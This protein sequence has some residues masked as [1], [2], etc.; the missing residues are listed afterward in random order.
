[1]SKKNIKNKPKISIII[2]TWNTSAITQKC[3]ATIQKHLPENFYEIIIVDNGSQDDTVSKLKKYNIKIIENK[4]NLGFAKANNI[5]VKH[6]EGDYL[7]FLNSDMELIDDSLVQM[8]SFLKDNENIG[9]IGPM[10]LNT[11]LTP[12]ASVFPPQNLVNA[13][14][15]FWLKVPAYSKY[16]P[17][18]E[19]PSKVYSISGG[20]FLITKKLF[21]QINGWN[22][23]YFFYFEDLDLCRQINSHSKDVYFYP[24]CKVIHHHGASGKN[25]SDT[26]N[27]WRR[28][29]PGS[30]KYH[31]LI[32][33][34]LINFVIWSGQ[35]WHQL[36]KTGKK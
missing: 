7:L 9:A 16:I 31:G 20:A 15:E 22:E 12:Q 19:K 13:F 21:K 18:S 17:A 28:L 30:I 32:K 5:G 3:V 33:H 34:Y 11:D 27:Q 2:V 35:K 14:K 25:L 1:M 26:S 6:A 36:L 10:F 29:I 24:R 4:M 8:F 23:K